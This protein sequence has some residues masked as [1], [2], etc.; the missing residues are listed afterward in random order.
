MHGGKIFLPKQPYGWSIIY[1]DT[2][3]HDTTRICGKYNLKGKAY[4]RYIFSQVTKW[5]YGIPKLGQK[6]H[7]VLLKH[8]EPYDTA[9]QAKPW[10]YGHTTVRQSTSPL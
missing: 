7:D 6:A 2:D 3:V 4:N 10:D 9:P 5:V 8:L 1:H